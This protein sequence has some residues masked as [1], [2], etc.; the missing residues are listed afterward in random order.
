MENALLALPLLACPV[1]MLLMMWMMGR[2]RHSGQGRS[3]ASSVADLRAQQRRISA[4]ID[5]L[6]QERAPAED[7]IP[8]P[9]GGSAP[10]RR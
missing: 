2:H 8:D 1:G 7:P 6:E 4:Q 5:R 10:G 9:V 3:D